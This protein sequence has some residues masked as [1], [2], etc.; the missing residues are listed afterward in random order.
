MNIN[1][2]FVS[3]WFGLLILNPSSVWAD[4]KFGTVFPTAVNY[5]DSDIVFRGLQA[6]VSQVKNQVSLTIPIERSTYSP[7]DCN[8]AS[9]QTKQLLTEKSVS[10]LFGIG[11]SSEISRITKE[12]QVPYVSLMLTVLKITPQAEP[13]LNVSLPVLQPDSSYT[14]WQVEV[15]DKTPNTS[16]EVTRLTGEL[17]DKLL[18]K[19]A[20]SPSSLLTVQTPFAGL[21]EKP[22]KQGRDATYEGENSILYV[23]KKSETVMVI[24]KEEYCQKAK[25]NKT[26]CDWTYTSDW[27]YVRSSTDPNKVGWIHK[28]L[29]LSFNNDQKGCYSS[30]K[31]AQ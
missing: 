9:N 29:L 19:E 3:L 27:C 8:D 15:T 18:P 10:I 22:A 31:K 14:T 16:Q 6:A 28:R 30:P 13:W 11:C 24:P 4:V 5:V 25:Q 7:N 26:Y 1:I 20:F 17:L 2:S 21:R 23:L 12:H